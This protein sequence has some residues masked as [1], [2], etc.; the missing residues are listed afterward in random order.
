MRP[1]ETGN[2]TNVRWVKVSSNNLSLKAS[3]NVLL[4]TCLAF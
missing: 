3:S 4:N 1:Q 2:K